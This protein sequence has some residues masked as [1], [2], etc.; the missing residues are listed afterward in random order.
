M[1]PKIVVLMFL[2][3]AAVLGCFVVIKAITGGSAGGS[4][5]GAGSARESNVEP[6]VVIQ[7]PITNLIATTPTEDREAR[8]E[9]DLDALREA[10]GGTAGNPES[11]V[12]IADRLLSPDA[13]VR[14]AAVVTASHLGD[15]NILPY[16][17]GIL[18]NIEDPHEKADIMDAIDYLKL[19]MIGEATQTNMLDPT[20]PA[21]STASQPGS[22]PRPRPGIK[23]AAEK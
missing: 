5:I 4:P 22:R 11:L 23:P 17:T 8:I 7:P 1:R 16:L 15:T 10:L 13:Q 9:K 21:P 6:A 3:A 19:L 14:K 20:N 12:I 18:P 2:L